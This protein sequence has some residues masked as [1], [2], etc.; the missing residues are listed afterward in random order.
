MRAAWLEI[1]L[2]AYRANL[3]ALREFTGGPVLAVVKANGYGHGLGLVARAALEAGCAGVGVALPEEGVALREGGQPGRILV[4]GLGLEEHAELLARHD[5]E[6][7]VTRREV[8]RALNAVGERAG[9]PIPL[10]LKVDTGMSRVGV[11]PEEALAMCEWIRSLS[12]VRL[13]GVLTHFASADDEDL[14][15]AR[16][17]W[18][19]FAPIV[20]ALRE[21]P[22]P[23][24]FHAANS[25]A[26]LWLPEARLDWVRGGL[27]TYGVEP[28]PRPLPVA[29]RPV[30]SLHGRVTQ[31][32]EIPAGRSVSYGG[33][34]TAE[35]PTRLALVPLGYGDGYPWALGNRG[36]ALIRGKRVP[37]RGRVC[38]DQLLLDVTDLPPL[39]PGEIATFIG[40]QG[41][42][43]I[44]VEQIAALVGTI[45]YEVLTRLNA[46]LPRLP[47]ESPC[48]NGG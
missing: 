47:V 32:K 30:L 41:D 14:T 22:E 12:G 46:R 33:T 38:M 13:A 27:L 16:E 20:A 44:S 2:G 7:V 17:Q 35:R 8:I 37:I 1:D 19:R 42:E 48:Y 43:R 6:P 18:A 3:T 34:W 10:H 26:A 5:L 4:L 24:L 39:A 11:E 31:V 45:P 25:A 29:V 40:S 36:S 21:L 28:A 9:C 15:S 23:P